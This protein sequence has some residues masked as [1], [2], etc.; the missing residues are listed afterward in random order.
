M[1]ALGQLPEGSA[2]EWLVAADHTP[3]GQPYWHVFAQEEM[4]RRFLAG[5]AAGLPGLTLSSRTVTATP[6]RVRD[7]Q[8]QQ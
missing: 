2:V 7:H 4:A 3:T 8:E 6:W 1:S 5:P